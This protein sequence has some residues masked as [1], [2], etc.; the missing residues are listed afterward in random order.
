MGKLRKK[1]NEINAAAPADVSVDNIMK[2]YDRESNTR[3]WEGWQAS[4]IRVII[5]LFS[6]YCMWSTLFSTEALEKRLTM[7]LGLIIVMG[8]LTYPVTKHVKRANYIPWFD[9]IIMVVGAG[10]FFY[11]Y[12]SYDSIVWEL[13]SASRMT[14]TF[15]AIEATRSNHFFIIKIYL[16]C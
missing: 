2:K 12:F 8:F 13:T 5:V 14:P 4:V 7:F 1:N 10:C 3:I 16:S 6:L 15:I 11:Y 9:W